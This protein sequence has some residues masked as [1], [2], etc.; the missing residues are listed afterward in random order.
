LQTGSEIRG[1]A[2]GELFLPG[3]AAYLSHHHQPGMAPQA[4]GEVHPVLLPQAR[5]ELSDGLDHPE[6]GPH[7]PLGIVFV[8]Q[9]VPEV[10][11]QAIAEILGD[12]PLKAGD[13]LGASLLIGAHHLPEVFGIKLAGQHR[14]VDEVTEQ[15]GELAAFG[16]RNIGGMDSAGG[17]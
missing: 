8:C 11:Q 17:W 9:G 4:Y 12:M 10:D 7:S 13:D 16:V 15:H 6:A 14:R 1:L 3:T 5:V 2:K